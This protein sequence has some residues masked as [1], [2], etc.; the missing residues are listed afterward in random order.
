MWN[1]RC[2]IFTGS[3]NGEI[4]RSSEILWSEPCF[5]TRMLWKEVHYAS[6]Y[7]LVFP[8]I[9]REMICELSHGIKRKHSFERMRNYLGIST[10]SPGEGTGAKKGMSRRHFLFWQKCFNAM[11]SPSPLPG[12]LPQRSRNRK[13]R[14]Q[15]SDQLKTHSKQP[16]EINGVGSHLACKHRGKTT[17]PESI[18]CDVHT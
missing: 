10:W 4:T 5:Q 8:W 3:D 15:Y 14:C 1:L 2:K 13:T 17:L 6:F 7:I 11:V 9:I 18:L 16:G 12:R